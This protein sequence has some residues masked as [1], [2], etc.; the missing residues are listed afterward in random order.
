MG[1]GYDRFK[2]DDKY[3]IVKKEAFCGSAGKL[4]YRLYKQSVDDEDK[5]TAAYWIGDYCWLAT[6][7]KD[8]VLKNFEFST[9]GI[10]EAV[11][12]LNSIV[13]EL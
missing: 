4:R 10:Y 6:P 11:D 2:R 7:D 13:S 1:R 8:K 3:P 12:W 9:E 5:L